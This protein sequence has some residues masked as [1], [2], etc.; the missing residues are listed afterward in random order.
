[1]K[2]STN[3]QTQRNTVACIQ[4]AAFKGS[5]LK[6]LQYWKLMCALVSVFSCEKR[7]GKKN[8]FHTQFGLGYCRKHRRLCPT[9]HDGFRRRR[10]I[11]WNTHTVT[12]AAASIL[13]WRPGPCSLMVTNWSCNPT[14][15]ETARI[16]VEAYDVRGLRD[17]SS[18]S[19]RL[20]RCTTGREHCYRRGFF[21]WFDSTF[22][23]FCC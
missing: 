21:Q 15:S 20:A 22:R 4:S 9:L 13:P 1:M 23:S 8:D 16:V 14:T 18:L 19:C 2:K 12:S 17:D 6:T 5:W 3:K 11:S 10:R 7:E